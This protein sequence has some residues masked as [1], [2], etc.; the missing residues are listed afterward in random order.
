MPLARNIRPILV[1]N[2]RC[3]CTAGIGHKLDLRSDGRA[4][5]ARMSILY[6]QIYDGKCR[7]A[8]PLYC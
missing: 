2:Q 6:A 5:E 4:E 3:D 7:L 1:Q 8:S